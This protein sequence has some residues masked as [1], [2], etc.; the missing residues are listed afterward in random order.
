VDARRDLTGEGPFRHLNEMV[1]RR[2]IKSGDQ[3]IHLVGLLPL[4]PYQLHHKAKQYTYLA[5]THDL[6]VVPAATAVPSR[7]YHPDRSRTSVR[8]PDLMSG[9]RPPT[10]PSITSQDANTTLSRWCGAARELNQREPHPPTM[11]CSTDRA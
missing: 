2:S 8:D 4:T 3:R 9:F 6:T 1:A 10:P 7:P 11:T 5:S